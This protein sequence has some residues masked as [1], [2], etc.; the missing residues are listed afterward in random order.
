[1]YIH[2]HTYMSM[3]MCVCVYIYVKHKT[4]SILI[5]SASPT[6]VTKS[7]CVTMSAY[8]KQTFKQVIL[9]CTQDCF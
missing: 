6:A 2:T 5:I 8:P 9:K 4:C 7:V 1:V 3:L